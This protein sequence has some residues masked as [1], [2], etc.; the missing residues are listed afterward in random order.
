MEEY[1]TLHYAMQTI[2]LKGRSRH[3]LMMAF[4]MFFLENNKHLRCEAGG[5]YQDRFLKNQR[6][7]FTLFDSSEA[8]CFLIPGSKQALQV[9]VCERQSIGI[10][11]ILYK[12]YWKGISNLHG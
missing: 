10:S 4:S 8:W 1:G 12:D 11:S 6:N 3:R 9:L 5:V 2:K 7:D